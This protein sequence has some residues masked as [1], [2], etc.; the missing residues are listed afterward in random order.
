MALFDTLDDTDI[1]DGVVTVTLSSTRTRGSLHAAIPGCMGRQLTMAEKAT[2]AGAYEGA[3]LTWLVPRKHVP[4]S[5]GKLKAGDVVEPQEGD[6][7]G[8]VFIAQSADLACEG[9]FYRLVSL[10]LSVVHDLRDLITI[11]RPTVSYDASG[12]AVL[13]Y[14][15]AGGK[16]VYRNLAAKVQLLERVRTEERLLE[17]FNG[18]H[19]ITVSK[20][21]DLQAYDRV[22]WVD[23]RTTYY[24]DQ[25]G[26]QN[27]ESISELPMIDAI[28]K[29]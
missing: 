1:W 29:V 13:T 20:Q 22:K 24:F 10:D 6:H 2:S 19:A 18:T 17:G 25:N 8:R 5:F 27:P 3:T 7:A 15:P 9:A 21:I 14:P 23:G 4:E 28:L 16:E 12:V 26:L 11:E